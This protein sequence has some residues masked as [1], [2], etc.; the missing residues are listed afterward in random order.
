MRIHCIIK[1]TQV[2]VRPLPLLA[3]PF[4]PEFFAKEKEEEKNK[5]QVLVVK[6]VQLLEAKG[7]KAEG[8]TIQGDP[9]E[10][11]VEKCEEIDADLLILGSVGSSVMKRMFVGSVSDYCFRNCKCSVLVHR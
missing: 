10:Q 5:A 11:I 8:I 3:T 1:L 7:I 4:Q 6:Y 2:N 9:R